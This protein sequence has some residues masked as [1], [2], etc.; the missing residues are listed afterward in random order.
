MERASQP[1]VIFIGN[2]HPS[3]SEKDLLTT[4][5]RYGPIISV[6]YLWHKSG[7]LKGKPKGY[8]FVEFENLA[9][10]DSA[11]RDSGN[12]RIRG[13]LIRIQQEANKKHDTNEV[14]KNPYSLLRKR[15]REGEEPK[16][17]QGVAAQNI[18]SREDT[19]VLKAVRSIDD[20]IARLKVHS[21]SDIFSRM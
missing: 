9:S 15:T 17:K 13:N 1:Q 18:N 20:R 16:R 12:V 14:N 21:L 8:A 10:V 3:T 2:L 7:P 4:F 5:R 11:L 19:H 6:N